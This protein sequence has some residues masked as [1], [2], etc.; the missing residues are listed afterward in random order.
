[1]YRPTEIET[2]ARRTSIEDGPTGLLSPG[3]PEAVLDC[4]TGGPGE[5]LLVVIG[6]DGTRARC[7][8]FARRF[9]GA[10]AEIHVMKPTSADPADEIRR[11]A[12]ALEAD[13]LCMVAHAR[14]GAMSLF[15]TSDDERILRT[16]PCPVVC[17]P[18]SLPPGREVQSAASASRPIRRILVPINSSGND[19]VAKHAVRLAKRFG[20]RLD[21]LG[22]EELIQRPGGSPTLSFSR[23]RGARRLAFR[24]ELTAL[25]DEVVPK[26]RRGRK[27]VSLGLP[28][29]YATL[30]SARELMPDLITLG[31][32]TRRWV[33]HGRIDVG[34]ER[35]LRG[36]ECP[37]ICF[38]EPNVSSGTASH[39]ELRVALRHNGRWGRTRP[40]QTRMRPR[41]IACTKAITTNPNFYEKNAK[42]AFGR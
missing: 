18:E 21:L 32:P 2:T 30:T 8:E 36:A 19:H 15:L 33:A 13:W 28:L 38:P 9:A 35:I 42:T 6:S 14:S 34:T 4:G 27:T 26:H 41:G 11:M 23:V 10:S 40:R 3:T 25:A 16:A 37:V 5:R 12:I 39:N 29:F 1:M 22:V 20:A 7:L 24:D 17:I 31:V